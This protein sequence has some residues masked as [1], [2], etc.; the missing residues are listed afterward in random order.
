MDNQAQYTLEVKEPSILRDLKLFQPLS[1]ES[2]KNNQPFVVGPVPALNY[3]EKV[4][5]V[6]VESTKI[7]S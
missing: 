1:A 4:A 5:K 7:A 3:D 6:T 2:F